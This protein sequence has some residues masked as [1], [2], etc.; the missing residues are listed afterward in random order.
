MNRE[1]GA[2]FDLDAFGHRAI[3]NEAL[4]RIEMHLVS[5]KA[6]TVLIDGRCFRFAAGEYILSECSHKYTV[7]EFAL[8]ARRAG[9]AVKAVWTDDRNLFSL[10][11]CEAI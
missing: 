6:Q 9:F 10:Q 3:Y 2:D 8:M 4:G 1:F 11:Y 5:Q 7:E